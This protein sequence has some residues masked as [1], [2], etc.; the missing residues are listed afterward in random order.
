[1]QFTV[2]VDG[3]QRARFTAPSLGAS[4]RWPKDMWGVIDVHGNVRSIRIRRPENY[5]QSAPPIARSLSDE[6]AENATATQVLVAP[7]RA[8]IELPTHVCGCAVHLISHTGSIVHVPH[9]DFVIGR[10]PKCSNL[11][12]DSPLMPNMVS[13]KHA[14]IASAENGTDV[15][16]CKSM[17]GT[18]LN[19]CKVE[20]ERLRQGDVVTIGNPDQVPA[21]FRFSISMPRNLQV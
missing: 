9:P 1:M 17:N 12:L 20:R 7:K 5:S 19:G 13:R 2:F 6:A 10:N 11:T 16:D 3:V 15:V 21:D 18:W 14:M 8:R 4:E